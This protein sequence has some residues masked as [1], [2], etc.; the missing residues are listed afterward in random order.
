[1]EIGQKVTFRVPYFNSFLEYNG[2]ILKIGLY[3][4]KVKY[5]ACDYQTFEQMEQITNIPK[6][7]VYHN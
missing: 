2:R 1:M 5:I 7:W 6:I 4:L 3:H